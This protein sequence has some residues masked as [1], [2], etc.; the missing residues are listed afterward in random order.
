[1][2]KTKGMQRQVS[3]ETNLK[4]RKFL[5]TELLKKQRKKENKK[6]HFHNI[7]YHP[8]LAQLKNIM[9][10][11]HIPLTADDEHN[12]V[13]RDVHIIGFREPKV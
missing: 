7:T 6:K 13:F 10:R 11:I 5:K 8:S 3:S 4:A 1:M 9:T 2:A 12:K